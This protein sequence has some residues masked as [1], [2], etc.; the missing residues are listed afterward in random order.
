[1][2]QQRLEV[3]VKGT[4]SVVQHVEVV[5][6]SCI[7]DTTNLVVPVLDVRVDGLESLAHISLVSGDVTSR[8]SSEFTVTNARLMHLRNGMSMHSLSPL[9]GLKTV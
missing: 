7:D 1:M 6:D 9:N 3:P 5:I 8:L 4:E 2:G